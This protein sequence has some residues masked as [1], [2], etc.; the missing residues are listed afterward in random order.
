MKPERRFR[1]SITKFLKSI[2]CWSINDSW[3]A[4]VP[5]HYYSGSGADLWA[6]YKFFPKDK[7]KFD[8]TRPPKSP[9]LTRAQ[10]NWLNSQHDRGRQVR[11]IVGFPG[12]GV[13]LK[14]KEWMHPVEIQTLW[15]RQE[16]ATEILRLCSPLPNS[17]RT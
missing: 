6:E 9:K 1:Q 11:V 12:G 2:Y 14:D 3:H 5:D 17:K 8:L 4:G 7:T 13:I 15:T 10:Q 16:I